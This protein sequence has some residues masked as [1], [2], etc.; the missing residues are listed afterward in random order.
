MSALRRVLVV[1]TREA[2]TPVVIE[3]S[4]G[5]AS[6]VTAE[7]AVTRGEM[8]KNM[9]L[10]LSAPFIGLLY[11]VLL[12][13]VGLAMLAWFAAKAAHESAG[14]R[15]ALRFGRKVVLVAAAPL[16]GL[17][18]VIVAPFAGI[19]MLAWAAAGSATAK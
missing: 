9:A 11:A 13:F 14:V 17:A 8:L 18:Y 19:A 10:F 5:T 12:P 15:T 7:P 4:G 6:E 16:V 2:W 1:E 3:G